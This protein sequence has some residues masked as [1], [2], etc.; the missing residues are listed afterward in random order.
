VS[1]SLVDLAE[2]AAAGLAGSEFAVQV[3][4]LAAAKFGA[5]A[6]KEVV[7][8]WDAG[9]GS[10]LLADSVLTG[11]LNAILGALGT[12][13]VTKHVDGWQLAREGADL[14]EDA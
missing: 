3:I 7:T 5:M 9:G 13:F 8:A 1:S 10:A 14:A 2:D 12:A 11:I 4:E 6:I